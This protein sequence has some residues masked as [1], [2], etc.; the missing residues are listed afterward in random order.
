MDIMVAIDV[1][2]NLP[3]AKILLVSC[4]MCMITS[5]FTKS[6]YVHLIWLQSACES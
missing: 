5:H 1:V 3:P 6:Y 4:F 2:L